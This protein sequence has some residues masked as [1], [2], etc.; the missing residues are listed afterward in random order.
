MKTKIPGLVGKLT[1]PFLILSMFAVMSIGIA[2]AL[3]SISIDPATTTGLN[4]SDSFSVDVKVDPAGNSVNGVEI[5]LEFNKAV[6]QLDSVEIKDFLGASPNPI[7][8]VIDN[9]NGTLHLLHTIQLGGSEVTAA[10]TYVKLNFK[11]KTDAI[12][13]TYNLDLTTAKLSNASGKVSGVT[14]KDGTFT[15]SAPTGDGGSDTTGMKWAFIS[16]PYMLDNSTVA[17]VLSGIQYDALFGFDPVNKI[18]VGGVTNF[19][20]VKG[21]LIHMN[22]SQDITNLVRKNGQPQVP[23]SLEIA[24]GWNLVGTS[25]SDPKDAETML[26]AI[27]SSYYSV[28]DFNVSTQSYD[29]IGINGKSGIVDATH[30]GTDEF[31]MQPKASYWV[32]STQETSLPAFSS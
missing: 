29:I 9:A 4:Q 1:I 11:V 28:W 31:M 23:P 12:A 25:A 26:G 8:N 17:S 18:Y 16:V 19:E 32:W 14:G 21:Y 6:V 27:D 30:V 22:T 20:P 3:P 2:Q 24:K 10:G 7:F 15:V 13:G 5:V